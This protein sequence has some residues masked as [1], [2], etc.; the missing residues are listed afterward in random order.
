MGDAFWAAVAPGWRTRNR[1]GTGTVH[2]PLWAL[3]TV[4]DGGGGL[5]ATMRT[6]A[7]VH[8]CAYACGGWVAC[9]THII[10]RPERVSMGQGNVCA[11]A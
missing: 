10:P 4:G 1:I 2:A 5:S 9:N 3:A 6:R 8:A 11:F 7:C